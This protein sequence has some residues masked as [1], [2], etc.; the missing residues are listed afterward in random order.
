MDLFE[1]NIYSKLPQT[2]T[3]IFAVMTGLAKEYNAVNLS[4]GFPDFPISEDLIERVTYYMKAGYNQYAPMT[5][6]EGLR[7]AISEMFRYNHDVFYDPDK[8]I[9]ITAGGTQALYAAIAAFIRKDD[10]VIIF[11]PAYDSY[12]PAVQL[13]GGV[14]KYARLEFPDFRINWDELPRLINHR[15]KMIVINSPHNPTGSVLHE[16]DLIM[17]ERLLEGRDIIVLS[18][19]VYEHLIFE[20]IQHQSVCRFPKLARRSLLVGSFGKTFHAT[21]WKTGFVLAPENLMKEF[22]KA[23]QFIVFA[24]N[25]PI[26]HALAD[27]IHDPENYLYLGD[28]Y[29]QKRDLF[30][31][32]VAS[33]RFKVL[34]CFG[35]YFQL[36][37]YSAISEENEMDFAVQLVKEFGIAAVPVSP[38]YHDQRDNKVLRFCFAKQEETI[39][40]AG[41]ILCKI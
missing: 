17:L 41:E 14:V 2:G 36:L 19:E 4:Q 20:N 31:Q 7:K 38:F 24:S 39:Q 6:V 30:V 21:G 32:S 35:T 10:E 15:T 33:S 34:P 5:G 1:G 18:D 23:H 8:E 9:N 3:S 26:Q 37:D 22:R 12:A 25:T 29:Q 27:Y 11:E 13:N 28:F 16:D 40:K